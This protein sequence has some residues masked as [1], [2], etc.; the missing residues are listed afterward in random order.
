MYKP[1]AA[2]SL[3]AIS[4]GKNNDAVGK[5]YNSLVHIMPVNWRNSAHL[6][7]PTSGSG[8]IGEF[9]KEEASTEK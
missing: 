7:Q 1:E 4:I 9:L 8:L 3:A 2:S 5:P 6:F